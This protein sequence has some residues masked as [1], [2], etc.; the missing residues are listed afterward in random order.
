MLVTFFTSG[1]AEE[2]P[3]YMSYDVA[4]VLAAQDRVGVVDTPLVP[5]AGDGLAGTGGG[6]TVGLVV[7][8]DQI[9]DDVEPTAFFATTF[10]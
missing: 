9:A 6:P 2:V 8:N 3:K 1:S 7:V 5:L 4:F 10:Q